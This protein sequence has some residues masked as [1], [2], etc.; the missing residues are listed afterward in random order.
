LDGIFLNY[1]ILHLD[2]TDTI[3]EFMK[4]DSE[5]DLTLKGPTK[6]ILGAAFLFFIFYIIKKLKRDKIN[7]PTSCKTCNTKKFTYYQDKRHIVFIE[8][9]NSLFFSFFLSVQTIKS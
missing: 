6:I 9:F 5:I 2:L 3:V 8:N 7:P 4:K 1:K